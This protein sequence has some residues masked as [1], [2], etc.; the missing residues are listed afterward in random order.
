MKFR[1]TLGLAE[2]QLLHPYGSHHKLCK[3]LSLNLANIDCVGCA[4]HSYLMAIN[5]W[6]LTYLHTLQQCL[7]CTRC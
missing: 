7:E 4:E 1:F 6:P 5:I 3:N 2:M